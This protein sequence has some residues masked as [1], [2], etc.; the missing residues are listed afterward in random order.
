MMEKKINFSEYKGYIFPLSYLLDQAII[1]KIKKADSFEKRVAITTG[2]FE[3]IIKKSSGTQA[4]QVVTEILDHCHRNSDF[5]TSIEAF[6]EQ[7]GISTR[8]L[9]RYFEVTTGISSKKALQILRIRQA[10]EHLA[11]SPSDFHFSLYGYYD[12]SHFYKHLKQFLQK[13]TLEKLKPHLRLL[14]TI[15]K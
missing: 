11:N 12:H 9:Q 14:E 5:N 1:D 10:A 4:V 7:Y 3:S 2:Y 13:G 6:A 15:H 8:T